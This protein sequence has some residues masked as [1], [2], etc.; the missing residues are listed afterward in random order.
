MKAEGSDL[1]SSMID[2]PL[3]KFSLELRGTTSARRDGAIRFRLALTEKNQNFICNP[4]LEDK[5]Y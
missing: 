2:S 4:N 5:I 1:K 3:G